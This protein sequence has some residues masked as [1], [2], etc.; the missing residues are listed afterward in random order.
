MENLT[1]DIP[2]LEI[3]FEEEQ[4]TLKSILG[5]DE[6]PVVVEVRGEE[7]SEI[8]DILVQV[9]EKMAGIPGLLNVQAS[10]E[11]GAPEVEV[12]ID[13][14]RAGMYNLN[15]G[16][17][18]SQ[19]QDQLE[20]KNAGQLEKAGDMRD[21]TIRVP[22]KGLNEI[23]NLTI[24]SG[25]Q[26]FRLS[27]IADISFGFSPKE[28]HRKNQS[29]TGKVTAQLDKEVALDQVSAKIRWRLPVLTCPQITGFW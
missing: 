6:A 26:V 8:D 25:G 19:I 13:R 18:I 9:K 28:I 2:G 4:S 24:N 27:E 10:T 15:I 29:R 22:E 7:L 3:S 23:H 21:I 17:V 14:I 12:R 20:G 1:R 11:E 5:T 16:T